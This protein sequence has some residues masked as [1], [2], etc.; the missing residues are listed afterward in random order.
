MRALTLNDP[1]FVGRLLSPV[2]VPKRTDS[3]WTRIGMMTPGDDT[4]YNIIGASVS[5]RF[6]KIRA[7]NDGTY[8]QTSYIELFKLKLI[9]K[10]G[11]DCADIR[12]GATI[13]TAPASPTT[14][15]TDDYFGPN[16]FSY[17]VSDTVGAWIASG[18]L[19]SGPAETLVNMYARSEKTESCCSTWNNPS[20]GTSYGEAVIDLGQVRA[21]NYALA[22]QST[23]DGRVTACE[24]YYIP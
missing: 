9:D 24:L 11:T 23:S 6:F 15:T 17:S 3:R 7:Y 1:G 2:I 10:S 22:F 14:V 16:A 8:G 19:L 20:P 12:S 18:C 21:L 5:G 4:S 13:G